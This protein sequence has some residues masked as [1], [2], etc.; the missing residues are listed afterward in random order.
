MMKVFVVIVVRCVLDGILGDVE[1]EVIEVEMWTDSVL[2]VVS[3]S[4]GYILS[5]VY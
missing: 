2:M 4:V 5:K 1:M 3:R